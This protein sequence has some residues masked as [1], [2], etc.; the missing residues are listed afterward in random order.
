[1]SLVPRRVAIEPAKITAVANWATPTDVKGV[2]SFLGLAGYYCR[3]VRNFGVVA[4]PLFNL[5][6]KG[7]QFAWTPATEITFQLVKQQL[8]IT[9]VLALPDFNLPFTVETATNTTAL[10]QCC[11]KK[12][13]PLLS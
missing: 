5:L 13:I 1:M 4:R 12:A 6:K 11:S 7:A 9:P 8:I 3:S 2:C 10:E